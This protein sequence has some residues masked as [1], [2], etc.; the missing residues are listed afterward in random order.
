MDSVGQKV[1]VRAAKQYVVKILKANQ[2]RPA[3]DWCKNARKGMLGKIW[4]PPPAKRKASAPKC[5]RARGNGKATAHGDWK[6]QGPI[7]VRNV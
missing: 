5:M 4:R 6:A 7:K 1:G 3:A 2:R